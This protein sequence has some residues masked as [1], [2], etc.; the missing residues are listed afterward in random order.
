VDRANSFHSFLWEV[1]EVTCGG[2]VI[3]IQRSFGRS[4]VCYGSI[5][6]HKPPAGIMFSIWVPQADG[7]AANIVQT[8]EANKG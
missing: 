5:Y 6:Q 3:S 2:M 8:K 4:N 7:G 1:M